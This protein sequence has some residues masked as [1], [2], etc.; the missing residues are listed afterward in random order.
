MCSLCSPCL[1]VVVKKKQE[2][3][4]EESPPTTNK[5][6]VYNLLAAFAMRVFLLENLH[7]FPMHATLFAKNML[8]KADN[9]LKSM[10]H[11][12]AASM[13]GKILRQQQLAQRER[14]GVSHIYDGQQL[15]AIQ[16]RASKIDFD[17]DQSVAEGIND[18]G[19]R[20]KRVPK[21]KSMGLLRKFRKRDK[22]L[23]S[24]EKSYIGKKIANL[25]RA[26]LVKMQEEEE[27]EKNKA[28]NVVLDKKKEGMKNT[29]SARAVKRK[30]RNEAK[31]EKETTGS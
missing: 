4:E 14:Q 15:P 30:A 5:Y 19:E 18:I 29:S 28:Q 20:I 26:K 1:T 6:F 7:I 17:N 3:E 31:R 13:D 10:Y 8:H 22:M 12:L 24:L 21:G 11:D 2:E 16:N 27:A 23:D 25:I 9:L